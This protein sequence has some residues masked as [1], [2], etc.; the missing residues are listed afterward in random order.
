[1][2]NVVLSGFMATGKSTVGPR[3]AARLGVPFVDTDE[4]IT[5]ACGR[6]IADLWRSEGEA[7][8]RAREAALV[9]ALLV[10]GDPRIIAFGGGT[11]TT[12][13]SRRLALDRAL[14]VTLT[15]SP[16]TVAARVRD[17]GDRPNLAVGSDAIQRARELVSERADAYGECH[18]MLSSDA[19][20]VETL[21]DTIAALVARDPLMVPL[22]T[23]SY[24]IDVCR[25]DPARLTD[26]VA[27][28][29]PSSLVVVTDSNVTRAR[30]VAVRA[31]LDPLALDRTDVTLPAGESQKT[32]ASVATIWDAALGAGVDRDAVV[33][34]VGGGV[35][36]DLAG[37]AAACLLRGVRFV[38]VPTTL[39]AMVDASV[40]GKTGF[41]HPSGKNLV[42]AFHQ[43]SAVVADLAHLET[44]PPR[45]RTAGLAE[46]VKI[47]LT[48]DA[49]LLE[50]LE[51]GAA[52]VARGER[53]ALE[54]I[55]RAAVGAKIR[56]VQE[57]EREAGIRA[58][59]NLGHTVGHALE[60][61]GGYAR[62]LHG[63]AVALGT[64]AELRAA[65]RLGWTPAALVD[66]AE[67]LLHALGLPTRVDPAEIAA[68]W[69]YVAS[70][71]K[72]AGSAVRL[73]IVE[74]PGTARIERV[75]LDALRRALGPG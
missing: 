46:I 32:L 38:Q 70:D 36:G 23:R 63:E 48:S 55:V 62:W 45:Q 18:L 15:A 64:V 6:S 51:R 60:A 69:P 58:V 4:A 1:M 28:L 72:R 11:V 13:K 49:A 12:R 27:R 54:P 44:L 41:D 73:P 9:E 25:N 42:G 47:A 29:A 40:G 59:L 26:A 61:H 10:E 35:V 7:A 24:T 8:F 50:R 75:R 67:S 3:L 14:V 30:G 66:R 57:D 74:S 39:L 21:V 31:A 17:L 2:R 19:S 71:K 20:D 68:S 5:R 37:F 34:A 43:P 65:E 52:A 53:E 33:V 56:I 22:G 16:E